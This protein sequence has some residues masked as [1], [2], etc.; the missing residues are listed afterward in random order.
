M[1]LYKGTINRQMGEVED[2]LL[3]QCMSKEERDRRGREGH[4][5]R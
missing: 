3:V 1:V 2:I 5:R 4:P